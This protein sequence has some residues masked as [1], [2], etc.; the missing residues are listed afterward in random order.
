MQVQNCE[1]LIDLFHK[2][3][4]TVDEN[5]SVDFA[6]LNRK[7]VKLGYVIHPDCCNRMVDKWL[8]TLT[9]NH[10][11]TFYKEW[12]DVISKDRFELFLDQILHYAT[13][14]GTD[15]SL[16]NGFVPNDGATVPEFKTLKVV[17]AVSVKE[18][19]HMCCEL[20]EKGIA[21]KKTTMETVC[22]FIVEMLKHKELSLCLDIDA[23]KCKEAQAYLCS[24]L[25]ILPR[26]EFGILRY[27]VYAHTGSTMLIKNRAMFETIRRKAREFGQVS[28]VFKLDLDRRRALSR[29]FLRYKPLILAMK[30][31]ATA[32]FINDISRLSRTNHVPMTPGFWESLIHTPCPFAEIAK[33]LPDLDIFRKIRL[34]QAVRIALFS[35]EKDKFYMV[36]NGKGYLR[37]DYSPKY[38]Q[39]YLSKLNGLLVESLVGSLSGKACRIRLP[40]HYDLASPSSEKSFVGN[41]PFG[42]EIGLLKHSVVG[43]Y[44]R[45]EWGARDIDLSMTNYRGSIV[46]WCRSHEWDKPD[47]ESVVVYS[48]DMT[49][50]DPE[51]SELLY[52]AGNSVPDGIVRANLFRGD[53]S[54]KFR[55][56]VATEELDPKKM[57]NHMVDPNNVRLDTMIEFEPSRTQQSL[58][59]VRDG[60]L[61]LAN[62][63][64][65][66]SKIARNDDVSLRTIDVLCERTRLIP[67]LKPFLEEAGF[68]VVGKD[69]NADIDLSDPTKDA[70]INL[71]KE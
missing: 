51:A 57:Y 64:T 71:L 8:D 12:N 37:K 14:Y 1:K 21:L 35:Q 11:A 20:V 58:A 9:A 67:K 38:S 70:I 59:I 34:L 27:L 26:D 6:T 69:E 56:F 18:M 48:G 66:S 17:E 43:I 62:F 32:G 54:S 40:E 44:W 33:R 5:A 22:D 39:T 63:S 68:T 41:L 28:P 16:G 7:A 42:T 49:N 10:N 45:D 25:D 19:F 31:K 46:S 2:A 30:T 55:F 61:V 65:G 47:G 3:I 36:R 60:K 53:S 4:R 13:T 23:V 15:F 24:K 50:A 52:M 29:I